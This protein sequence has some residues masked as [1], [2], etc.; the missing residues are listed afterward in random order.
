MSRD[1]LSWVGAGLDPDLAARL[2]AAGVDPDGPFDAEDAWRR[3]RERHGRRATLIDRYALE[4]RARGV[5]PDALDPALLERLATDV[6]RESMPGVAWAEGSRRASEDPI[7]VVPW[8]P[9]WPS[10]YDE[11]RGRLAR[12]LGT[13]A[14]RIDH[15]GSTSVPG[16]A[17]KPV[18]DVQ[19]SVRDVQDEPSYVPAVEGVGL[20]LRMREPI[21]RY[22]R[23]A[24]GRPRAIHVHVCTAGSGW[25]R[26]HLLFRDY[27]RCHGA[28]ASEY[29]R[30][31]VALAERYRTDRVAY[32]EA[33]TCFILDA[34]EVAERWAAA[35]GWR[36]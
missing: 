26:D 6:L 17:A 23:P 29:G 27:L 28:V 11:W 33:K 24:E 8:D 14:V 20:W 30:H 4:A 2:H 34:L 3:L 19:V 25:E 31:K 15:V 7:E 21:H 22:F 36:V 32:T 1:R 13:A 5:T 12:A 18:I 9:G 35:T 10:R 16:L